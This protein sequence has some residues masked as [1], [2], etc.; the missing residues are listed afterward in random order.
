MFSQLKQGSQIYILHG[1]VAVP[2]VEIGTVE[3][4]NNVM[5]MV[6][7]PNMPSYPID[8]TVRVADKTL[9]LQRIPT[10]AESATVIAHDGES[11][12]I[13]CSKEAVN[14]EVEAMRIKSMDVINSVDFHKSRIAACDNL[15][16]QLNP[17]VAEKEHQQA[18]IASLKTQINELVGMIAE[19]KDGRTSSEKVTKP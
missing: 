3:T 2:F 5:P 1:N 12:T 18:E 16:K 4:I 15:V 13:A 11:I 17:E 6:Y 8:M 14:N 7:Y 19:L 10:N 9:P